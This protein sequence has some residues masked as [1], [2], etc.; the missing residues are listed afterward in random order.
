MPP[1]LRLKPLSVVFLSLPPIGSSLQMLRDVLVFKRQN[2]IWCRLSK[3][4]L[5]G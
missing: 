5:N 2:P 1:A 3:C 4:L